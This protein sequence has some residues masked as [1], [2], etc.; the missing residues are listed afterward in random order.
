MKLILAADLHLGRKSSRVGS[1]RSHTAID[2]WRRIVELAIAEQAD[3]VLLAGDVVDQRNKRYESYPPLRQGIEKLA[4]AEIT[5]IAVSGN[6]DFD[7]LPQLYDT[8][9]EDKFALLGRDGVWQSRVFE[10]G[11]ERL[12]VDGWCFPQH[13][14]RKSPLDDYPENGDASDVDVRIGLL[15]GDLA[16]ANSKYAP[17]SL[18]RLCE[19]DVDGWLL[20]HIHKPELKREEKP[21]VLYPG[22][23]QPLDPGEQGVHG[24]WILDTS[25]SDVPE[26]KPLASVYYQLVPIPVSDCVDDAA[27]PGHVESTLFEKGREFV[28]TSGSMLEVVNLR[29][30]V[31]GECEDPLA[32]ENEME[33]LSGISDREGGV[34][35]RVEKVTF[36]LESRLN[37]AEF[38][39]Q[40]TALAKAV[41]LHEELKGE[42][43]SAGTKALIREFGHRSEGLPKNYSGIVDPEID[44]PVLVEY[45]RR[46]VSEIISHMRAQG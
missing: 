9:P 36:E 46:Q 8:I 25:V 27:I 4:A 34:L 32:V 26:K 13:A 17:L 3:A 35:I 20:G 22:S 41:M 18:A 15:H 5:T 44:E 24:V 45:L 1:N 23:P 42:E 29:V 28:E 43:F 7:V 33:N 38:A 14:Y 40:K 2:G 39:G 19:I 6:H 31:S 21:W 16:D 12:G 11:E 10:F 30:V 37:P